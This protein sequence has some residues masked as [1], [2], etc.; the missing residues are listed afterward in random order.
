MST[1]YTSRLHVTRDQ[2]ILVHTIEKDG[3]EQIVKL[4][5]DREV[6]KIFKYDKNKQNLFTKIIKITTDKDDKISVIDFAADL[7][8]RKVISLGKDGELRWIYDGL[9]TTKINHFTP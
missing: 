8:A 2:C 7:T 5:H 1:Q 4:G 9:V 3:T 6:M